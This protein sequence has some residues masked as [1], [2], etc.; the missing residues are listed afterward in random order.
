MWETFCNVDNPKENAKARSSIPGK[1]G[2][3]ITKKANQ[4]MGMNEYLCV[5][6]PFSFNKVYRI[7]FT[8]M[9]FFLDIIH[10]PIHENGCKTN[11]TLNRAQ[12]THTSEET[13]TWYTNH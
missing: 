6:D 10:N 3:S 5:S 7:L 8:D 9:L 2:Q 11:P 13:E 4:Y 1:G 12:P